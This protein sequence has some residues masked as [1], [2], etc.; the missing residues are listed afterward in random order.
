[1]VTQSSSSNILLIIQNAYLRSTRYD[2]VKKKFP[3]I[4]CIYDELMDGKL[5][6]P[7]S[8]LY[9]CVPTLGARSQSCP[10]LRLVLT[11]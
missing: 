8:S 4:L 10:L 11:S 5:T 7:S 3:C 2:P 9:V 6:K 1:M